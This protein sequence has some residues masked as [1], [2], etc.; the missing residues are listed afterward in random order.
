MAP[1]TKPKE[2]PAASSK[3]GTGSKSG[4]GLNPDVEMIEP[5]AHP[6]PPAAAH[7]ERESFVNRNNAALDSLEADL[8]EKLEKETPTIQFEVGRET[9]EGDN[10]FFG[11]TEQELLQERDKLK[12]QVELLQTELENSDQ[13]VDE[14]AQKASRRLD[15]LE[16]AAKLVKCDEQELV[17]KIAN[18]MKCIVQAQTESKDSHQRI[19]FLEQQLQQLDIEVSSL[20]S[21]NKELKDL[22][23]AFKAL[24]I[25]ETPGTRPS[26]KDRIEALGFYKDEQ[27]RFQRRI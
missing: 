26:L 21:E 20:R 5:P 4:N 24:E 1:G 17:A 3:S 14:I 13:H 11:F 27:G 19:V 15:I 18:L 12:A 10:N 8:K 2:T 6:I 25:H 7:H 22:V 16:N 9:L 23:D